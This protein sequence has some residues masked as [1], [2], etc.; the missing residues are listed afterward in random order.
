MDIKTR[1]GLRES[2]V[3]KLGDKKMGARHITSSLRTRKEFLQH[4]E[5]LSY[6]AKCI[7]H[8]QDMTCSER[9]CVGEKEHADD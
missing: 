3:I 8:L 5:R 7:G 9:K 2:P 1:S 4:R 6:G